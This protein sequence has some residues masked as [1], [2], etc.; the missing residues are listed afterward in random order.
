MPRNLSGRAKLST[1]G[2]EAVKGLNVA[3]VAG[4]IDHMVEGAAGGVENASDRGESRPGLF[5]H[6]SER[7]PST[8]V[9][10]WRVSSMSLAA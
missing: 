5:V 6:I 4:A 1:D 7:E 2:I 3:Q 8:A 9:T 10:C